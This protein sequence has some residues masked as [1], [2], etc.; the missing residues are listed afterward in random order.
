[1]SKEEF[2]GSVVSWLC[3]KNASPNCNGRGGLRLAQLR[4]PGRSSCGLLQSPFP[5]HFFQI[6]VTE[7]VA[8]VP[9]DTQE[10][11]LSFEVTP[12]ERVLLVHENNSSEVLEE[13]LSLPHHRPFCNTTEPV[14]FQ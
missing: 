2:G 6:S 4:L 9:P 13:K 8:Q 11:D 14:R 7:R 1:M 3:C 5:H 10:N 12:F